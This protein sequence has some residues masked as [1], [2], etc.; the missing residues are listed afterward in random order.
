MMFSHLAQNERWRAWQTGTLRAF[1]LVKL[2]AAVPTRRMKSSTIL[3]GFFLRE[4]K[5]RLE[6]PA[7]GTLGF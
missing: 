6:N 4:W 3:P 2:S 7:L 1:F 5:S